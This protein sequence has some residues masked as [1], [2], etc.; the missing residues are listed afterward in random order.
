MLSNG[1]VIPKDFRHLEHGYCL[2][3]HGAHGEADKVIVCQT[4]TQGY[5]LSGTLF[6][7]TVARA[8]KQVAVHTDNKGWLWN[9]LTAPEEERMSALDLEDRAWASLSRR[10]KHEDVPSRS[11]SNERKRGRSR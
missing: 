6:A 1:R 11:I 4:A 3:T 5:A 7:G 2:S 8:K 9:R 10:R